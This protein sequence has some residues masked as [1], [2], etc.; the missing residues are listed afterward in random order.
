M[1]IFTCRCRKRRQTTT[2]TCRCTAEVFH[3][4]ITKLAD[5]L[6][7]Y[8]ILTSPSLPMHCRGIPY[9]S[10]PNLPRHCIGIP[11]SYHQTCRCTAEI[12]FLR[13]YVQSWYR[14]MLQVVFWLCYVHCRGQHSIYVTLII[15]AAA[16]LLWYYLLLEVL[17]YSGR[18]SL[19]S[20]LQS[21]L[22]YSH[23]AQICRWHCRAYSEPHI[24]KLAG[25]V[26]AEVFQSGMN[27][28][29]AYALQRYCILI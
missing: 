22:H 25:I 4:H 8:S 18:L 20:A 10:S 15:C 13:S 29:L 3:T 11:Y 14:L 23:E 27:I 21:G 28:K 9:S 26:H 16:V 17:S 5:A 2:C 12:V 7:R 6:Q 24:T 19:P 1:R